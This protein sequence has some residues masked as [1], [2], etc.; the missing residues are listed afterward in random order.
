ML[1]PKQLYAVRVL[2]IV[3]RTGRCWTSS[4]FGGPASWAHELVG[5]W[6]H[7]RSVLDQLQIWWSSLVGPRLVGAQTIPDLVIRARGPTS[8]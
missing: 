7:D 8:S 1:F 4:G 5:P 2:Y 3:S 6:A